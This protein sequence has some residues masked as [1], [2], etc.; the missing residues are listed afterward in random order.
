V[1]QTGDGFGNSFS[2]RNIHYSNSGR[3]ERALQEAGI[4]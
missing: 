4:Q 3:I 2:L 1:L